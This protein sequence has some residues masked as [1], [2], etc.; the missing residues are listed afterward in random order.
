[1]VDLSRGEFMALCGYDRVGF[2]ARVRRGQLPFLLL[3]PEEE[4]AASDSRYRAY[5]AKD[6]L[7]T[8]LADDMHDRLGLPLDTACA[9]VIMA[10][11]QIKPRWSAVCS[12]SADVLAGQDSEH[13]F[14]GG[15]GI[16]R[17]EPRQFVESRQALFGTANEIGAALALWSPVT[18]VALVN[19]TL[20]AAEL[21]RRAARNK[22]DIADLWA[23]W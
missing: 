2:D 9:L 4:R 12:T 21:R 16:R 14:C 11:D 19:I 17:E 1:M 5:S 22:I 13:L 8:M 10:I 7:Y 15:V 23:R 6:A 3:K 18:E 20:V